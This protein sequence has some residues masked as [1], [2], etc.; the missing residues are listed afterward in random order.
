MATKLSYCSI[1]KNEQIKSVEIFPSEKVIY[2]S[3]RDVP[4]GEVIKPALGANIFHNE[5]FELFGILK[6][7]KNS[8]KYLEIV[9]WCNLN[10]F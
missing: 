5:A 7:E 9:Q 4:K 3:L 10:V 2:H 6:W 1:F 8:S